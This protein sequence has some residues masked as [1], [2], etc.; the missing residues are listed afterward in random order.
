MNDSNINTFDFERLKKDF[1]EYHNNIISSNRCYDNI[2]I[3]VYSNIGRVEG[4][5]LV[6]IT[7]VI[8]DIHNKTERLAVSCKEQLP[9]AYFSVSGFNGRKTN[10][11]VAKHSG[12]VIFD[13]DVKD[14]PNT[15]FI[16]LKKDLQSSDYTY[17]CFTSP[18]G[19]IKLIVNTYIRDSKH[20]DIYYKIIQYHFLSSFSQISKIDISGSNIARACYLPYDN[21]AYFN[22][23]ASVFLIIDEDIKYFTN[24]F[25]LNTLKRDPLEVNP[26]EYSISFDSH[27]NNILNL[28]R[29]RTSI[30]LYGNENR[31]SMG[32]NNTDKGTSVGLYDNIFNK[33]S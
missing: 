24:A 8:D 27:F 7:K 1:Q 28:L 23:R 29:N 31:T 9:V 11:N 5:Q 13:I 17:A 32:L 19:G 20:H 3:M 21:E 2:G 15:D 10:A 33:Y 18:S 22:P 16:Q 14:N 30:G 4:G 25:R 26:N 12:L 6:N